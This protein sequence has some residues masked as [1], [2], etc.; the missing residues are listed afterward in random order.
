M[1]KNKVVDDH[2]EHYNSKNESNTIYMLQYSFAS[3]EYLPLPSEYNSFLLQSGGCIR[4]GAGN[5]LVVV[6][7]EAAVVQALRAGFNCKDRQQSP[8]INRKF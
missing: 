2:N 6:G 5:R 4:H 8:R 7:S 3:N 1:L